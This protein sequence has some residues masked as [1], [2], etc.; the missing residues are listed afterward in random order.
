MN[1][2]N[3]ARLLF[4]ILFSIAFL[5]CSPKIILAQD[6]SIQ[7][8]ITDSETGEPLYGANVILELTEDDT[9]RGTSADS[10]GFYSIGSIEPG[11]W[12]VRISFIGYVAEQDTISLRRGEDRSINTALDP[13][14]AMMDEVVVSES[15]GA[16]MRDEGRQR[17]TPVDMTRVPSPA[18]GDLVTYLQTLPGVVAMG[19]RGG[20]FFIR[21]G[22]PSQNMALVDGAMIYKPAH[23]VGF[24]SPFPSSLVS[25]AD[26]Y[27]GGFGP[28][29]TGRLS[30]VLDIQMRHGDREQYKGSGSISPFAAE[31]MAEGPISK[32]ES[33]F[34][35]SMRNSLIEET[36]T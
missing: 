32:G 19:D 2:V 10:D 9:R 12:I 7:G 28:R 1:N 15:T 18:T 16:A 24:Y 11:T 23:I 4:L 34:V 31:V 33:S 17:I 3:V 22:T 30:S 5:I 20:Q 36:S 14:D 13:D 35:F 27:A 25:G 29:Y 8:L 6:A 21:G 26:F